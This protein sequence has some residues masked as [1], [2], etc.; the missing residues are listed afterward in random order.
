MAVHAAATAINTQEI[1]D[2]ARRELLHHLEAVGNGV[3]LS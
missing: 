1:T 3:C 2:K